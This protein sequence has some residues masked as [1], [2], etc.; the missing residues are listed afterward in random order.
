MQKKTLM[1]SFAEK[2]HGH[3]KEYSRFLDEMPLANDG[4][5]LK[6]KVKKTKQ[7]TKKASNDPVAK[8]SKKYEAEIRKFEAEVA[9]GK[10]QVKLPST[11]SEQISTRSSKPSIAESKNTETDQDFYKEVNA[12]LMKK[13]LSKNVADGSGVGTT[14]IIDAGDGFPRR[15]WIFC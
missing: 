14:G 11:K 4:V 12:I 15:R 2:R 3:E 1:M 8:I 9:S 13:T 5:K 6:P 7:H 10:G